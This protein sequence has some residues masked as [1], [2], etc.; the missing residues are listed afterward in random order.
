MRVAE[1]DSA[2][3]TMHVCT[4]LVHCPD[5]FPQLLLQETI[6]SPLLMKAC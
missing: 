5:L 4:Y 3:T 6:T 2:T 1:A